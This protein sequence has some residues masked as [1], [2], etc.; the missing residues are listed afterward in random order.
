MRLRYA[1]AIA[2]V[3]VLAA[4][5]LVVVLAAIIGTLATPEPTVGTL[6]PPAPTSDGL[7]VKG[8]IDVHVLDGDPWVRDGYAAY[9]LRDWSIEAYD[10]GTGEKYQS[11]TGKCKSGEFT[12]EVQYDGP[13]TPPKDRIVWTF[14]SVG[15]GESHIDCKFE[16]EGDP[17]GMTYMPRATL[18]FDNI[19]SIT[20][21]LNYPDDITLRS[22]GVGATYAPGP[23]E[24]FKENKGGFTECWIG[25]GA[26]YRN[27]DYGIVSWTEQYR[28]WLP[29]GTHEVLCRVH[30]DDRVLTSM[31]Y[32]IT[33]E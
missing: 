21:Y 3:V 26:N 4:I 25:D 28:W 11:Y 20:P 30:L 33:V 22:D 9:S 24:W 27:N 6:T 16:F 15:T 23:G 8:L 5:A 2:L 1:A 32:S 17:Y 29:L 7:V 31:A 12:H 10:P 13:S 14:S 18:V 19:D